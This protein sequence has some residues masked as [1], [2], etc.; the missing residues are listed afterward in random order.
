MTLPLETTSPFIQV[1]PMEGVVDFKVRELLTAIGGVD[2]TVTEFIRVTDRLLPAKTFFK[3]APELA[4]GGRT[5]SGVPVFLQLLGSDPSCLGENA[6]QA[7]ELGALGVDLNF[8]CPAKTVN[9]HDGG[10]TLLKDPERVFKV[11]EGVRRAVASD[12][13][14]TAKVRLGFEDKG[15]HREIAQ[16]VDSGGADQLVI[17]ARTRNEGY[18]PPAHWEYIGRMKDAV[19]RVPVVAN[20]DLWSVE[21]YR[22]CLR[23]GGVRD[24]ALGRALMSRPDLALMI[25]AETAGF[26]R[27]CMPWQEIFSRFV[28]PLFDFYFDQSHALAAG[29]LKQTLKA[30]CRH[31]PEA[32]KL[33]E[34]IKRE[35]NGMR[36]KM[37]L[38]EE[39]RLTNVGDDPMLKF[40]QEKEPSHGTC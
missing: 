22:E 19:S 27:A 33:F 36:L 6:H 29:R 5:L 38:I 20:G 23:V 8:G 10:A 25:R 21:D 32:L 2:R 13:P 28:K 18:R 3:Y 34:E 14:V 11:V 40:T 30:L 24:V 16:A 35:T 9:R 31:F 17:H 37:R 26:A 39:S 15:L 7:V 4:H 1:A 12:V